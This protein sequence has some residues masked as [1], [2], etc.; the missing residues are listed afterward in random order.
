MVS[1]PPSLFA[2]LPLFGFSLILSV[3]FLSVGLRSTTSELIRK[4]TL[5]HQT[6]ELYAVIALLSV[7]RHRISSRL[8]ISPPVWDAARRY[9]A[10]RRS[11][12]VASSSPTHSSIAVP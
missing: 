3:G 7:C 2:R 9:N 10:K 8:D 4:L 12:L 6:V 1:G 5:H 11:C